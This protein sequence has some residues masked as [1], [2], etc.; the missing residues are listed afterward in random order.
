MEYRIKISWCSFSFSTLKVKIFSIVFVCN[1]LKTPL[2]HALGRGQ[3]NT[4]A[5][6]AIALHLGTPARVVW[7]VILLLTLFLPERVLQVCTQ[8]LFLIFFLLSVRLWFTTW[9]AQNCIF[10]FRTLSHNFP[11]FFLLQLQ[12]EKT[13]FIYEY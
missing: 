13:Y 8:L 12:W 5:P 11:W 7:P 3:L 10:L 2:R 1:S 4:C 6:C 9:P